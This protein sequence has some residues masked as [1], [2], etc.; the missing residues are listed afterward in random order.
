MESELN[1]QRGH[2]GYEEEPRNAGLHSVH[3][4]SVIKKVDL[5]QGITPGQKP[6]DT[7]TNKRSEGFPRPSAPSGI[8]D[9]AITRPPGSGG[10]RDDVGR[11]T[12]METDE[13]I[14]RP[15][16]PGEM[17]DDMGRAPARETTQTTYG[18]VADSP[19]I[20]REEANVGQARV[21][22]GQ[23]KELEEDPHSPKNLPG[24]IPPSN[25]QSKVV[26]P[27]GTGNIFLWL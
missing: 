6:T 18:K 22:I 17:R 21:K 16:A 12:A 13:A 4:S 3:E 8:R 25:H 15:S 19:V 1:R 27:T 10:K 20:G 26:D 9:E 2:H 5:G 11:A 7:H 14:T 23:P 24:T